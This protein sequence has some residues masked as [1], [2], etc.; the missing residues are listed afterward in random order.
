MPLP[1]KMNDEEMIAIDSNLPTGNVYATRQPDGV[2]TVIV[3]NHQLTAA[4]LRRLVMD[5]GAV[6]ARVAVWER[7]TEVERAEKA[8][9]E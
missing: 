4:Q 5:L 7:Q 9:G 6:M 3:A 2:I 8:L 1:D